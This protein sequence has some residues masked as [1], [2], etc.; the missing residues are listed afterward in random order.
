M[1]AEMPRILRCRYLAQEEMVAGLW[2]EA[3]EALLDQPPPAERPRVDGASVAADLI[4]DT[5]RS[6]PAQG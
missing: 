5:V 1:L 4:L 3:I 2:R 6:H